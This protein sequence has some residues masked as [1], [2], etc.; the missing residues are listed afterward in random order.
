MLYYR[1]SNYWYEYMIE[2]IKFQ[3]EEQCKSMRIPGRLVGCASLR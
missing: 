2:D 1:L 3:L